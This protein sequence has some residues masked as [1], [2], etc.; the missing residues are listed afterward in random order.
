MSLR[1]AAAELHAAISSSGP[2]CRLCNRFTDRSLITLQG[3][4][5]VR[6]LERILICCLNS[7][8]TAH[9]VLLTAACSHG[10]MGLLLVGGEV[11]VAGIQ[12]LIFI[13]GLS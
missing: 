12:F 8:L 1:I 9:A 6:L 3:L 4:V 5:R 13:L 11:S 10:L 2:G 7:H